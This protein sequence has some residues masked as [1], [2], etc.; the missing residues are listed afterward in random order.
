MV[1]EQPAPSHA[2][3]ITIPPKIFDQN[4]KQ[5][6]IIFCAYNIE[7]KSKNYSEIKS[8]TTVPLVN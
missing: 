1:R 3:L 2:L 7:N 6:N 4:R 5:S 8:W